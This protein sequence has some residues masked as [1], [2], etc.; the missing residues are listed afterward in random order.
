MRDFRRR[1]LTCALIVVS[2]IAVTETQQQQRGR[3]Q[4]KSRADLAAERRRCRHFGRFRR[5]AEIRPGTPAPG[6]VHWMRRT[7]ARHA[8][9]FGQFALAYDVT[10]HRC[11]GSRRG[12]RADAHL[13]R[14]HRVSC[15]SASAACEVMG[16]DVKVM[17]RGD[18]RLVAI[19]GRPRASGGADLRWQQSRE[20]ALAAALRRSSGSPVSASSITT[21]TTDNA[22]SRFR[23]CGEARVCRCRRPL[24]CG[25]SC[26]RSATGWL[27]AWVTEFY[28]GVLDSVDSAGVSR[29]S[30]PPDDGRVLERR[31][32]TGQRGAERS[33][34]SAARRRRWT[35]SIACTQSRRI[36]GRSMVRSRISARIR[37]A[38]RTGPPHRSCR[39]IS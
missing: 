28:A 34:G 4:Q 22:E 8:G 5:C 21:E 35:S 10:R 11:L 23:D 6:P 15:A 20:A 36:S 9:I 39:R 29:T 17:M 38:S 19:S 1:L 18:H 27:A 16:S 31:N 25:R 7:M 26:S 24:P 3:G 2:S 32:L 12:E 13:R 33:G 37:P 30:S 14:R